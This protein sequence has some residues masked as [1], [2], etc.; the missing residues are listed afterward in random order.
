VG[1]DQYLYAEKYVSGYS[2]REDEERNAYARLVQAFG[3]SEYIDPETPSGYVKFTVAYWRKA[4][5]IHQWFVDN[6]QGGEDKC[7]PH[8]VS[9]EQ[10][11][12][13]RELCLRVIAASKLVEDEQ[14][15]KITVLGSPEGPTER[16][17]K[18]V[19]DPAVAQELLPPAEGFFFGTYEI[20]EGYIDDLKSTVEQID[21]VLK[22]PDEWY[23]EYCSSW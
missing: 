3:V 16:Q 8:D 13:L 5:Q 10:L 14:G 19:A 23:L 20:D 6:V 2:F 4:N 1:L 18:V 9:R 15:Q 21:R 12:E 11:V 7:E 22:M 17:Y